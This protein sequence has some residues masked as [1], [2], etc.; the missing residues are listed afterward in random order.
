MLRSG[1]KTIASS[2]ISGVVILG[3]I[4]G[5]MILITNYS[6]ERYIKYQMELAG[7]DCNTIL[8]E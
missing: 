4:E 2:F 1:F 6:N 8:V 5:F 7:M 3:M